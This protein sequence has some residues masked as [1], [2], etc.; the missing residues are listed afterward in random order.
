M[1]GILERM[2]MIA[3]SNVN[4]LF[5]KFEDP[6]KIVDQSII[7]AKEDL[8]KLKRDSLLT[9][10]NETTVK[11]QLY[12]SRKEANKWH[13]RQAMKMMLGKPLRKKH[14]TGQK[15][16]PW[17]RLMRRRRKR[18]IRSVGRSG[19]WRMKLPRCRTRQRRSKRRHRLRRQRGQ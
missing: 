12:G 10:A 13:C 16:L 11:K 1:A 18:Q 9:L 19:K 15:W 2:A 6:E 17:K 3:K 5:D 14:C 7:E 4:E 8:A